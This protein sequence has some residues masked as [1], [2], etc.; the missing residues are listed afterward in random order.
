MESVCNKLCERA[1]DLNVWRCLLRAI[2]ATS[3]NQ[4]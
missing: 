2:R 1:M 4:P 3:L